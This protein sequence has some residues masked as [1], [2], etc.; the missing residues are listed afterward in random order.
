MIEFTFGTVLSLFV[1]VIFLIVDWM[2]P[3]EESI[4]YGLEKRDKYLYD[5]SWVPLRDS[6][7]MSKEK[8]FE[9]LELLSWYNKDKKN[10][11]IKD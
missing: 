4:T 11:I 5:S 2:S 7:M 10:T 6:P 8:K 9:F 1:I 3:I